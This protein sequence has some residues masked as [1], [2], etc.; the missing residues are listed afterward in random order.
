M[1]M[2]YY[3]LNPFPRAKNNVRGQEK[4]TISGKVSRSDCTILGDSLLRLYTLPVL[5][6]E[7]SPGVFKHLHPNTVAVFIIDECGSMPELQGFVPHCSRHYASDYNSA[8]GNMEDWVSEHISSDNITNNLRKVVRDLQSGYFPDFQIDDF[9]EFKII[10]FDP[11]LDLVETVDDEDLQF[12]SAE[13]YIEAI[14]SK[15]LKKDHPIVL[16]L[17]YRYVPEPS[18][19]K[20]QEIKVDNECI[21]PEPIAASE[22]DVL[23]KAEQEYKAT[24]TE[25]T[26]QAKNR[27]KVEPIKPQTSPKQKAKSKGHH[28]GFNSSKGK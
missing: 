4:L 3:S 26:E 27:E 10:E 16:G 22:P 6:L 14:K 25:A 21:E 20:T 15:D 13:Q 2:E 18:A 24:Q 23:A 28:K 11:P 1:T 19:P 12:S 5:S 8:L 17:K 7:E 9:N